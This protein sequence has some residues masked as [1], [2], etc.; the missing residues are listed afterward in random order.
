ME[1]DHIV[2]NKSAKDVHVGWLCANDSKVIQLWS[3]LLK[4]V[5]PRAT[6]HLKFR[7][8]SL[9]PN[10][11]DLVARGCSCMCPSPIWI[12]RLRANLP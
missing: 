12:G 1:I 8:K 6:K 10:P 4:V 9:G 3:D 2:A 5:R 7:I 11:R